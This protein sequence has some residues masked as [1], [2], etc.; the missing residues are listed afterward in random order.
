MIGSTMDGPLRTAATSARL[1]LRSLIKRTPPLYRLADRVRRE[2][3]RLRFG[4]QR[5]D[6]L[7]G[8]VHYADLSFDPEQPAHYAAVAHSAIEAI[9]A[10]LARSGRAFSDVQSCLDFACGYG[11]VLRLLKARMPHARIHACDTD[12][13]AV[14]FCADEFGVHGFPSSTRFDAVAFPRAYD[15][16]WVGSLFTHLDREPFVRLLEALDGA[17]Q[18]GGVLIFTTH[19]SFSLG[20]LDAYG[21]D[22]PSEEHVRGEFE[23]TGFF[24]A[25]YAGGN[26]DYGV[27]LTD[28]TF[29]LEAV[30]RA[31]QG[32]LEFVSH[33]PRGWDHHQDTYV[34][35][36]KAP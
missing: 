15:L 23:R 20:M 7:P 24:F 29:V 19:G 8:R 22:L 31:T 9:E 21:A 27:A 14:A 35:R 30:H 13:R 1:A 10:G 4:Y 34:F 25:P 12:A 3:R 32:R 17:L 5:L 33:T 18:P 11:R 16:I 36:A 6:G 2:S 28:P 26:R